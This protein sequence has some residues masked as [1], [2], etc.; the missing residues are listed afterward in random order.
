MSKKRVGD[1]MT[2]EGFTV[3]GFAFAATALA[4]MAYER[5]MDVLHGPYVEGK[6]GRMDFSA[7]Q[8]WR[9]I[10]SAVDRFRWKARNML[11]LTSVIAC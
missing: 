3:L 4:A 7:G 11:Y 9:P 10:Q 1:Q 8:F 5:R 6:A 2:V